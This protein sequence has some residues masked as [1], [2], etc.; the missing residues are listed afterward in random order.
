VADYVQEFRSVKGRADR[1]QLAAIVGPERA[2]SNPLCEDTTLPGTRY[3]EAARL[4][5]GIQAS[6]CETDWSDILYELGLNAAGIYTTFELSHGAMPG[7]LEVFIDDR[8]VPENEGDGYT[9]DDVAFTIEF[10]GIWVPERGSEIRASYE[11]QP[12]T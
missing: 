8:P 3:L 4:T 2:G 6:I 5:A 7:T 10:H 11:I 1:V 12:G 9:Y